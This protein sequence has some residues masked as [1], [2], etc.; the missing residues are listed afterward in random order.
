MAFALPE[1]SA[2]KL[3]RVTKGESEPLFNRQ[4]LQGSRR[5]FTEFRRMPE[6]EFPWA[7]LKGKLEWQ[8]YIIN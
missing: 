6:S 5:A 8:L 4:R 1:Q 2:D 3:N 7:R